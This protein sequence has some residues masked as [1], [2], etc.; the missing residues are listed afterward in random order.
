[1]AGESP[2]IQDVSPKD[3]SSNSETPFTSP[4][5]DNTRHD[6]DL[7]ALVEESAFQILSQRSLIR[8]P[9]YRLC[10]FGQNED[11][12]F[13]SMNFPRKL[14]KIVESDKF[15]SIW[16]D[17]DG[18]SIVI[19]EEL[20]KKEVLERKAAFRIFETESMKS[21]VRQ[22]NL[23]GFSKMRQSFQRSASLV[24]F[25]AEEKEVSALSK[26]RFY[27]NPNF[28]RGCPHLLARMRRRVGIKNASPG[29]APLAPDF[30]TRRAKDSV[31]KHN[32]DA[33]AETREDVR[34]STSA[35]FSVPPTREASTSQELLKATNTARR[36]FSPSEKVLTHH[37][38]ALNQV[39]AF[40]GLSHSIRTRTNDN[41]MNFIATSTCQQRILPPLRKGNFG[42]W[43]EPST[44]PTECPHFSANRAP[45]SNQLPRGSPSFPASKETVGSTA[46]WS[47]SSHQP[48]S[49]Q[50]QHT[51]HK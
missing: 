12:D 49:L 26:L 34:V 30:K 51:N 31:D 36:K 19:N 13:F 22:L 20:F 16:W 14:W 9:H 37:Q 44:F 10:V 28:V 50:Q 17:E 40:H 47:A 18:T 8:N 29:A 41:K 4:L 46:S 7:R 23:Y 3:G 42:L 24:D 11:H 45:N 33:T 1:M 39:S 48:S 25:L 2:E 21:L 6:S 38:A 32:S 15:K 35:H 27:R 5:C 43:V